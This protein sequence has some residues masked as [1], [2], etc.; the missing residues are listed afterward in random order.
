MYRKIRFTN[1]IDD[2][3]AGLIIEDT[4][5]ATETIDSLSRLYPYSEAGKMK[6]FQASLPFP[7]WEDAFAFQFDTYRDCRLCHSS[8][9]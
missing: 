1:G 3:T 6:V 4:R 8:H 9:L 7:T 2:A 5:Y